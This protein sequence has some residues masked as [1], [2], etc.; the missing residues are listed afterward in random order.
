PATPTFVPLSLHDA[1]PILVPGAFPLSGGEQAGQENT[2]GAAQQVVD[3]AMSVCDRAVLGNSAPLI[4]FSGTQSGH[5]DAVPT[6]SG[7]EQ[8]RDSFPGQLGGRKPGV[9]VVEPQH[10]LGVLLSGPQSSG[11]P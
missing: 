9:D 5:Y 10:A 11:N 2:V 4:L 7:G 1:L 3:L 8:P 6:A